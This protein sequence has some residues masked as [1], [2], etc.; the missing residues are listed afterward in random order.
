MFRSLFLRGDE[1][2]RASYRKFS[3]NLT[4]STALAKKQRFAALLET[5]KL[6]CKST[7]EI[8]R[9]VLSTAKV[10]SSAAADFIDEQIN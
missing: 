6:N 10:K 1:N 3:N 2:E 5:K 8:I 7:W 9:S 4:K